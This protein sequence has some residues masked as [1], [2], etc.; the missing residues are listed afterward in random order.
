MPHDFVPGAGSGIGRLQRA[1]EVQEV[2]A[3][4]LANQTHSLMNK[5]ALLGN[6]AIEDLENLGH[7]ALSIDRLEKGQEIAPQRPDLDRYEVE[8]VAQLDA[9]TLVFH[10]KMAC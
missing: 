7:V 4:Q 6:P 3:H 5:A 1:A 2:S 8:L 10:H 9:L